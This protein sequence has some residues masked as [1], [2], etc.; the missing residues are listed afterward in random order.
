MKRHLIDSPFHPHLLPG[1]RN[2]PDSLSHK[3]QPAILCKH[4][5]AARII[6]Q[7]PAVIFNLHSPK[8]RSDGTCIAESTS[9]PGGWSDF[10]CFF[11]FR[12]QNLLRFA[13]LLFVLSLFYAE[14]STKIPRSRWGFLPDQAAGFH[15]SFLKTFFAGF[16]PL[17][18]CI[19]SCHL[20]C[21]I[22][23]HSAAVI[24]VMVLRSGL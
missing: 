21:P 15:F 1:I 18:F 14:K 20:I 9:P 24:F 12:I 7:N 2:N 17:G 19:F 8:A 13:G 10:F 16:I 3:E 23:I 22:R 6:F 11:F 4:A 5:E